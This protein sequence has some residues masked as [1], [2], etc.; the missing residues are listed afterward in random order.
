[1]Y[2]RLARLALPPSDADTVETCLAD[3]PASVPS[4]DI[5]ID[6]FELRGRSWAASRSTPQPRRRSARE[7]RLNRVALSSPEAQ[8]SGTAQ[9]QPVA[10]RAAHG[11]RLQARPRRQR[12]LTSRAWAFRAPARRQGAARPAA[13]A[14]SPLSLHI[15]SLD[16]KLNLALD[17][18]QFLKAAPAPRRLLS[19][20]SLQALPRRLALDFRDLFQEGFVFDNVGGDVVIDDGVAQHQ[21]PAHA[22]RAGRGADGR[23]RRHRPRDAGPARARRARDQ[24]RTASLAY[25]AINR[26]SAWAPSWRSVPAPAADR[27]RQ[28]ASSRSRA[29]GTTPRSSASSATPAT[30]CPD[31]ERRRPPPLPHAEAA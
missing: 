21:Q 3:A 19:V 13:W 27:R 8:L 7:W 31:L 17:G 29:P 16:G 6:D 4:L 14:G 12:G 28:R 15:P 9:W 25:A 5:V 20:L 23:P 2:A 1:V 30:R 24:R 11:A 18:G 26:P 10:G 22:R